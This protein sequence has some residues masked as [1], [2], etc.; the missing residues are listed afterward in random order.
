[1]ERPV[2]YVFC[3]DKLW[4]LLQHWCYRIRVTSWQAQLCLIVVYIT[5][6][7][8]MIELALSYACSA[9][10]CASKFCMLQKPCWCHVSLIGLLVGFYMPTIFCDSR[11]LWSMWYRNALVFTNHTERRRGNAMQSWTPK[12]RAHWRECDCGTKPGRPATNWSIN[13]RQIS[14]WS[15]TAVLVWSVWRGSLKQTAKQDSC[16][17]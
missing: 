6:A 7:P 12:E 8:C 11:L 17:K 5:D 2:E 13:T 3:A 10:Y 1:M 14:Y 4:V 16:S 15:L 9:V